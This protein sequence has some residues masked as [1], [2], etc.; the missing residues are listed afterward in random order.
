ML[1]K[2][3][4]SGTC[5]SA[6]KIAVQNISS[7]GLWVLVDDKEYFLSFSRYPWFLTATIEQILNVQFFHGHH[8]HWPLLDIDLDIDALEHPESYP[9]TYVK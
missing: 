2:L 8:M 1:K 6:S 5:I 3:K 7:H 4:K 9:L